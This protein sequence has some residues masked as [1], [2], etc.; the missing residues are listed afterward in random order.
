MARRRTAAHLLLLAAAVLAGATFRPAH[1]GTDTGMLAVTAT[2]LTGCA[3]TGGTLNFGQYISG[4][5]TDLDITGT[6]GY[7]NCSGTLTFTLDGG[8]SANIN[9]RQMSSGSN[10]LNYQIFRTPTRNAIW[11]TGG[12]A[13][14]VTLVGTQTA[15]VG[16]YGRIPGGQ[17]VPAGT[18]TDTVNI[19][20]TF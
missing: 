6:I 11:G 14:V 19:T 8:G 4:Q 1:A 3:L 7:A 2:V 10:R 20:L 9:A 13:N 15:T 17:T 5:P 12:N 18:Y 16:V